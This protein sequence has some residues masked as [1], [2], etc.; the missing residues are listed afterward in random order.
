MSKTPYVYATYAT[1]SSPQ[2]STFLSINWKSSNAASYSS[3]SLYSTH[4]PDRRPRMQK[5]PTARKADA[6]RDV[7]VNLNLRNAGVRWLCRRVFAR[8]C[9][10][11]TTRRVSCHV[12]C[13]RVAHGTAA[14]PSPLY[15]T[16]TPALSFG[17]PICWVPPTLRTHSNR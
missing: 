13:A 3:S 10:E 7:S 11:Q 8:E 16:L 12:H 15:T 4:H 6:A 17:L 14:V 2:A 9:E 5:T 1:I